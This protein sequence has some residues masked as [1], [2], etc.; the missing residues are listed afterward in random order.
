[1]LVAKVAY[2]N[3]RS[4]EMSSNGN[5]KPPA[6]H[7]SDDKLHTW[8]YTMLYPAVLGTMVVA[9]L[10]ALTD[11]G[12]DPS[13]VQTWYT[14]FLI[15]FFSCQHVENSL[16]K[17][18][19]N[20]WVFI[21]DLAEIALMFLF[22]AMLAI[23]DTTLAYPGHSNVGWIWV[24]LALAVLFA[25]PILTR[26]LSNYGDNSA[27]SLNLLCTLAFVTSLVGCVK[28]EWRVWVMSLLSFLLL[29]YILAHIFGWEWLS[30]KLQRIGTKLGAGKLSN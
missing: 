10:I 18:P 1:M 17:D 15:I 22:M 26:K 29:C 12:T 16:D 27:E 2:N 8:V 13:G 7:T 19:Y 14:V 5:S 25:L 4:I 6:K 24:P 9:L 30:E 20:V 23:I 3:L 28:P 11:Q 21:V